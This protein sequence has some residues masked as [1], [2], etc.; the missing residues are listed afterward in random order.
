MCHMCIVEK[1]VWYVW[2]GQT[3]DIHSLQKHT[4]KKTFWG[5]NT[6][7]AVKD[8]RLPVS[9]VLHLEKGHFASK[10]ERRNTYSNLKL[11]LCSHGIESIILR[12]W[13]SILWCLANET[14]A[15]MTNKLLTRVL[16]LSVGFKTDTVNIKW[17]IKD[18]KILSILVWPLCTDPVSNICLYFCS[19][20]D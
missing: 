13:K 15:F 18:A 14:S 16:W 6:M 7:L 5:K 11:F 17:T 20:P 10:V 19:L 2:K 12:T 1:L 4:K 3:V 9:H 8:Y